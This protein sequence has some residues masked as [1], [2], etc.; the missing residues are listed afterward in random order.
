MLTRDDEEKLWR[1]G[2]LG[3]TT[4]QQLL[5]TLIFYNGLYF[6]LRSGMEYRQLRQSP[7][8]IQLVEKEGDPHLT[9]YILKIRLKID[10]VDWKPGSWSLKL[11]LIMPTLTIQIN[12]LFICSRNTPAYVHREQVLSTCSQLLIPLINN[13]IHWSLSAITV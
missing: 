13:G 9:W 12:V 3:D 2:L 4:P 6:A 10:P 7:C 1:E 5:D 8:Q 11:S